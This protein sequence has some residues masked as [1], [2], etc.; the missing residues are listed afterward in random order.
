MAANFDRLTGFMEWRRRDLVREGQKTTTGLYRGWLDE[1]DRP[2]SYQ[3]TKATY[4]F[5]L[6]PAVRA[7][8]D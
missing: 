6:G 4:S 7:P 2:L 5:L 1:L 8:T 3:G